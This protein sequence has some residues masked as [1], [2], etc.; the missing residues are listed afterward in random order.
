MNAITHPPRR[1]SGFSL[2]EVL[3]TMFVIAIGLL[4]FAGLQAY[5]LKSNTLATQ[6]SLAAM[7][8]HSIIES[9]RANMLFRADYNTASPR[10]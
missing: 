8:S 9:I 4:G 3:V 1:Q 2:I 5:S 7:H 10:G 6:R